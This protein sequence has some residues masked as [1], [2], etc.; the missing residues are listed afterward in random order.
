VSGPSKLRTS[1][2]RSSVNLLQTLLYE[3]ITNRG[4]ERNALDFVQIDYRC[5]TRK[6][7]VPSVPYRASYRSWVLSLKKSGPQVFNTVAV[8]ENISWLLSAVG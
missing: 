2:Q 5:N 1:G 3:K 4:A 8:E 7:G 6:A